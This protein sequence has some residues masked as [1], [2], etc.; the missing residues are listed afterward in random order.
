MNRNNIDIIAKLKY[1]VIDYKIKPFIHQYDL[2]TCSDEKLFSFV[3]H[4]QPITLLFYGESNSGKTFSLQWFL[5]LLLRSKKLIYPVKVK[6]VEV[7]NN[8]V[9][10]LMYNRRRVKY[11]YEQFTRNI[12]SDQELAREIRT[13]LH[14][15]STKSTYYNKVS[16]RSHM[17]LCVQDYCIVDLAGH[18]KHIDNESS[19]I[20]VSLM[21]LQNCVKNLSQTQF[22][23]GMLHGSMDP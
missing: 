11:V 17:I 4:N 10:D 21:H 23:G 6:C 8:D 7:Y 5:K 18:E 13:I 3:S 1:D 15:R 16:S 2:V 12:T 20:N 14:L 19:F 9:F 22:Y